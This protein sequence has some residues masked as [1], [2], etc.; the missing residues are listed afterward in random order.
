MS[1]RR[2]GT[3]R[4]VGATSCGTLQAPFPPVTLGQIADTT[5]LTLEDSEWTKPPDLHI[6]E[7]HSR[8]YVKDAVGGRG[9]GQIR[10]VTR[11]RQGDSWRERIWLEQEVGW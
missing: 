5:E 2:V 4:Q 10:M 3:E 8:L 1:G 7:D 11:G 6:P 9:E